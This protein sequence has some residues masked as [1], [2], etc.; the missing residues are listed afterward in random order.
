MRSL[1]ESKFCGPKYFRKYVV[2]TFWT[3]L[4]SKSKRFKKLYQKLAT[5]E[6]ALSLGKEEIVTVDLTKRISTIRINENFSS[7]NLPETEDFFEQY[8]V[9]TKIKPGIDFFDVGTNN[10]SSLKDR[11]RFLTGFFWGYAQAEA[12][13]ES[14]HKKSFYFSTVDYLCLNL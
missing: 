8:N 6:G 7:L 12:V 10:W 2:E 9:S 1:W 14:T 3:F 5:K 11:M 13:L 4:P